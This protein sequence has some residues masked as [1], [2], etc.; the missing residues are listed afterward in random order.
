MRNAPQNLARTLAASAAAALL[1]N[2]ID[3][4][5]LAQTPVAVNANN[6]LSVSSNVTWRYRRP[7]PQI[8]P[9]DPGGCGEFWCGRG[10]HP[11]RAFDYLA[12][13]DTPIGSPIDGVVEDIRAPYAGYNLHLVVIKGERGLVVR[14]LYVNPVVEVGQRVRIGQPIG[15]AEN[16]A[17]VRYPHI[18]AMANH[19]HVDAQVDGVRVNVETDPRF[20][21]VK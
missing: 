15:L 16:V 1:V 10:D 17:G 2:N 11:H 6:S 5:T 12:K 19:V 20:E 7:A 18:P 9:M 14:V 4:P 8:R 13:V 21:S 3:S